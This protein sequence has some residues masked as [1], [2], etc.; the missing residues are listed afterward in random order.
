MLAESTGRQGKRT[1]NGA[2]LSQISH[3]IDRLELIAIVIGMVLV[4]LAVVAVV[5]LIT[6]RSIERRIILRDGRGNSH[7]FIGTNKSG[8]NE[9]ILWDR[10]ARSSLT[11]GFCD[12]GNP[13]LGLFDK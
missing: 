5:S 6:R 12:D 11:M 10:E 1:M 9:F 4:A 8:Q 7:V 2:Q 13:C 3:R